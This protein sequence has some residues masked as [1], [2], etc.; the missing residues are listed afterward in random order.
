MAIDLHGTNVAV[1]L[2]QPGPIDTDIWDREGED[3][4]LFEIDKLPPGLVAEGI[5]AAIEGGGFE[6]Y[7]P[8]L[9]AVVT[10][11]DADIDGY[12]A[13]LASVIPAVPGPA[14]SG[15]AR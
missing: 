9:K 7:L 12:I 15:G 1:K 10:G 2:I 13:G 3:P 14:G 8:D 4:A 11:K 5:V 6:H